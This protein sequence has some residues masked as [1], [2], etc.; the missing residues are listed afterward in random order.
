MTQCEPLTLEPN[1]ASRDYGLTS[2]ELTVLEFLAEGLT[3]KEIAARL[4]LSKFTINRD[5]RLIL[6]KLESASRTEAAI[7]AVKLGVIQ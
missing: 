6:D 1:A 7:K 3:D 4:R 2:R 5:V